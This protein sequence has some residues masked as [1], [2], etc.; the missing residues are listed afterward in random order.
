MPSNWFVEAARS[1]QFDN[2]N[3]A[4]EM[5]CLKLTVCALILTGVAAVLFRQKFKTGLHV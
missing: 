4:W 3:A 5:P 1:L 2:A